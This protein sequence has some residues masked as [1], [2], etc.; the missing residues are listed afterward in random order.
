MTDL[1]KFLD[2]KSLLADRTEVTDEVLEC[3][4]EFSEE[5]VNLDSLEKFTEKKFKELSEEE[6]T[7]LV[8]NLENADY[9]K[10]KNCYISTSKLLFEK[11]ETLVKEIKALNVLNGL[12][13]SVYLLP[14][15]YARNNQNFLQKSADSIT[16]HQ[17]LEFKNVV[18]VGKNAGYNAYKESRHQSNNTFLIFE[19]D[20]EPQT[21]INNI[22]RVIEVIRQDNKKNEIENNFEGYIFLNFQMRNMSKLYEI[23]KD[24]RTKE[25]EITAFGL[26]NTRELNDNSQV[27]ERFSNKHP[28]PRNNIVHYYDSVNKQNCQNDKSSVWESYVSLV[29]IFLS[30][31]DV[32]D[33]KKILEASKLA[34][35]FQSRDAGE[36]V[37]KEFE[38]RGVKD[39]NTLVKVIRG[40]AYPE[41]L[42]K[43]DKGIGIER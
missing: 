23:N 6:K 30:K 13:Y 38:K 15:G 3:L 1:T 11:A 18:S 25:I 19:N 36:V 31:E 10:Y 39:E 42:K 22:H 20:V 12:G 41:L 2:R 17:F 28:L 21:A 9:K 24:G 4:Y 29:K 40:A 8:K 14:F 33:K 27:E 32:N 26:K 5:D 43:K 35:A 37:S 34:L 16:N 7:E